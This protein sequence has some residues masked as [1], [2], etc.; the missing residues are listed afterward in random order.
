MPWQF[1]WVKGGVQQVAP[2]VLQRWSLAFEQHGN[3][4]QCP[5]IVCCWEETIATARGLQPVLLVAKNSDGHELI[6]SLYTRSQRI[7][8]IKYTMIEPMGGPIQCDYQDPLLVGLPMSFESKK[9]FWQAFRPA[10][11]AKFGRQSVF[12]AYRISD[13][14]KADS[15]K[16]IGQTV[17]PYISLGNVASLD[18]LLSARGKKLRENV[19]KGLKRLRNE[20]CHSLTRISGMEIQEAMAQFCRTYER[21]WGR[22]GQPHALQ[23]PEMKSYWLRLAESAARLKKLHFTSMKVKNDVWHWHLGFEHR[24]TLLWYKPTYNIEHAAYSPGTLHLAL[25]IQDC[26]E[27]GINTIDL[28][29]GNEHYKSRWTDL[30]TALFSTCIESGASV[31]VA[32]GFAFLR[33]KLQS[34]ARRL[35]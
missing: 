23:L 9:G 2:D 19:T 14:A 29:Y 35:K 32:R 12:K 11:V 10:L 30:S 8:G 26:I 4:W 25:L 15:L 34:V 5:D 13:A 18:E 6:Y 31:K 1:N 27:R 33:Q 24:S 28:G 3:F 21:Q 7:C 22:N 17:A 20:G 16:V